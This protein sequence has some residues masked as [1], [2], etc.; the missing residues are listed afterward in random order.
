MSSISRFPRGSQWRKW[1][2][3]IHTPASL[4]HNYSGAD[5]WDKFLTDLREL[6]TEIS[7][8]GIN[9]YLFI[10]GYRRVQAEVAA[11]NLP[12]LEA[13]FPVV[14][15]RLAR[16]AGSDGNLRR[17]N[18]HIIF[19]ENLDG[20][21]IEAQ[22]I[23]GL[24]AKYKLEPGATDPWFGLIS[25]PNLASFG[26]KIRS[27]I[28]HDRADEF[29][30]TDLQ[31]GFNNLNFELSDIQRLLQSPSL[32]DRYIHAIGRA[33]W[34]SLQWNDQS[35]AS[36]KDLINEADVVFTA[37]PTIDQ[38][39]KSRQRLENEGINFRLLDC[40]D[41][42]TNSDNI[43]NLN[44]LGQTFTWINADP[45]LH[46]LRKAL[47][48]FG[49]RVFVGAEPPKLN[50]V[51]LHG[52]QHIKRVQIHP[53]ERKD[54]PEQPAIFDTS[55]DLNPGFVAIIGN[56][57]KGKSALLD[58]IGLAANSYEKD[59]FS[60]LRRERFLDPR[61]KLG[62]QYGV[63]LDWENGQ[64]SIERLDGHTDK[65]SLERATYFPQR[66]LDAICASD[67]NS[68]QEGFSKR[69]TE[70]LFA[71]VPHESRLGA[72]DLE[73]LVSIRTAAIDERV[74]SLRGELLTIN[75][76]IAKLTRQYQPDRLKLLKDE[77]KVC[78]QHVA[79][80][81]NTKPPTPSIPDTSADP[82]TQSMRTS[83]EELRHERTLLNQE[84]E[85]LREEDRTLAH[86][87]TNIDH[88]RTAIE[89]LQGS[90]T[91]FFATNNSRAEAVQLE[92]KQL[93]GFSVNTE[94]LDA[95]DTEIRSRRAS[96]ARELD[97]SNPS[98]ITGRV[99]DLGNQIAKIETQLDEPSRKQAEAQTH[100]DQWNHA[101]SR[102]LKGGEGQKG[103]EVLEESIAEF[104][105]VPAKLADLAATQKSKVAEI[106]QALK[107]KVVILNDLYKPAQNFIEKHELAT[108]SGLEFAAALGEKGFDERFWEF[109]ARNVSGAFFGQTEASGKLREILDETDFRSTESVCSFTQRLYQMISARPDSNYADPE[110]TLRKGRT[111]EE[112]LEFVFGLSYIEPFHLLQYKNVALERLSPGEKG[113][114]LLMFHLLID[115]SRRPL[116][117]DQPDE[118]LDN[119]TVKD[120]LAPAIKEASMRR[121]ILIITH[122]PNVAVV[123]DA[124]QVV[125]ATQNDGKFTY[126]SGSLEC[127]G[128]NEHVVNVLE[129]TWP[130]F[131]NREAKY[132]RPA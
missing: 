45:T 103:K 54:D 72:I 85:Q 106:H 60:F 132:Q 96:I 41:S 98:G 71:H 120:F 102:A 89:T 70:V 14:E 126:D 26:S 107:Q 53:R 20:E 8:I 32:A 56:K 88:L 114:L 13:I 29:H 131:G 23:N 125:I 17:I 116:L 10:E 7:V 4:V 50:S 66:L 65:D 79:D 117:L 75:S 82:A 101:M 124:D 86:R 122:N 57:G 9:D 129:G 74:A 52:D 49:S 27:T 76:E 5:P 33:E 81:E 64:K 68:P 3:H 11:G 78:T 38:Y 24:S 46:G 91:T 51:R 127:P 84:I 87:A 47:V 16:F 83:L 92:L 73:G 80:L 25:R 109:V 21:V 121:Q 90:V 12:N 18:W 63:Q 100:L 35:I 69:L 19:E 43:R 34:S 61:A 39:N 110:R 59:H 30:E 113:T 128:L 37:A 115:P 94:P 42:H 62:E 2:L 95:I 99:G 1:D 67:P 28:P 40:S 36:K 93:V 111:L 130:A 6:P 118:N 15:L 97:S 77:L 119:E 55:I 44:R 123:A 112:L 58:A 31:L 22:F 105:R 48:E 104:Y 108:R